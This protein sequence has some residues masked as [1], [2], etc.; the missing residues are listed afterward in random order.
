MAS[1]EVLKRGGTIA[2]Y[3]ALAAAVISFGGGAMTF[4][5]LAARLGWAL[6]VVFFIAPAIWL[7]FVA[8]AFSRYRWHGAW[9]LLTAPFALVS[10]LGFLLVGMACDW[11]RGPCI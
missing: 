5:P 2:F 11:G 8:S 4:S 9:T 3:G 7:F 10:P 6:P 1:S